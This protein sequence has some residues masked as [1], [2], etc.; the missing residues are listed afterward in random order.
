MSSQLLV[1]TF[2]YGNIKL[3][4]KEIKID[5][6][7]EKLLDDLYKSIKD[8]IHSRGFES[9]WS[10]VWNL[11]IS[12]DINY[13]N[14]LKF[15]KHIFDIFDERFEPDF[16]RVGFDNILTL[17]C[18]VLNDINYVIDAYSL[19][20]TPVRKDILTY[21]T[22]TFKRELKYIQDF[23]IITRFNLPGETNW[24]AEWTIHFNQNIIKTSNIDIYLDHFTSNPKI[25]YASNMSDVLEKIVTRLIFLKRN[26]NEYFNFIETYLFD[27]SNNAF[28]TYPYYE[29]A[30]H[31]QRLVSVSDE[32]YI[33]DNIPKE[34]FKGLSVIFS[35]IP[36]SLASYILGYPSISMGSLTQKFINELIKDLKRDQKDYFEK[37]EQK[38]AKVIDS[39][40]YFDKCSNYRESK[41]I[42]NLVYNPVKSYN[43]DDV[44]V[45][46]S[47]GIYFIFTYP[48]YENISTKEINPYNRDPVT[49][50][51]LDQISINT[52]SKKKII[53]QCGKRGLQLVLDGTMEENF[54]E[55]LQNIKIYTPIMY[56]TETFFTQ[57]NLINSIF[58]RIFTE[59]F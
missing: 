6:T 17:K 26:T 19:S 33:P 1:E 2:T 46:I 53:S 13:L 55:F 12:I 50:N 4:L 28:S 3:L 21:Y 22:T 41:N 57:G 16:T 25:H 32:V 48:E 43:I 37:L 42:L 51:F 15:V 40:M 39:K 31:Y 34:E 54:H 18:Y 47:N 44:T 9:L 58:R 30:Q 52:N 20:S 14:F 24:I 8:S 45:T 29:I 35:V 59:N 23:G 27:F 5:F 7:D 36:K 10:I 56:E 38:N 11:I 49:Q